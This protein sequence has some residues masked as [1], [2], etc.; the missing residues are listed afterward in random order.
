MVD[1]DMPRWL[2]MTL[3]VVAFSAALWRTPTPGEAVFLAETPRQI[4]LPVEFFSEKTPDINGAVGPS[5]LALL[6]D[7]RLLL[8]WLENRTDDPADASIRFLAQDKQGRWGKAHDVAN[9]PSVA[10]SNLA[11]LSQLSNPLLY[12]EGNWL[13]L[14][15]VSFAL[16]DERGAVLNHSFSSDAGHSWSPN[17]KTSIAAAFNPGHLQ[18]KAPLPLSDGGL[19]LPLQESRGDPQQS[20]I[21]LS[22]GNQP[23]DKIRLSV[24]QMLLDNGPQTVNLPDGA[25]ATLQLADGSLLAAG[26]PE[27]NRKILQLWQ[28]KDA[29]QHWLAG[30]LIEQADDGAADFSYPFLLLAK[31]GRIHLTYSWRRQAIK[32]LRF[33]P[34]WLAEGKQP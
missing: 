21:R 15:F 27:H 2:P 24:G 1:R 3:F 23:L 29:G 8:S 11:Y 6:P 16:G 19:A 13:H 34:A 32:H 30:P 17:R 10:G 31:D 28:S 7:G 5:S 22:A 12:A 4:K 14:W 33:S 25:Q 18:L 9:R 20:W 26:Q